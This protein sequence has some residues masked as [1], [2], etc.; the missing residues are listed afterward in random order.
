VC[1]TVIYHGRLESVV[2]KMYYMI[3]KR[4]GKEKKKAP[5]KTKND[6]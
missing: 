1:G 5:Q 2:K 4:K 6:K 3:V